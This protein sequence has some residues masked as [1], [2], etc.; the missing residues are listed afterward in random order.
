MEDRLFDGPKPQT[1]WG[2]GWARGKHV[3]VLDF[4]FLKLEGF[5]SETLLD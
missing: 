4:H 5:K 3:L 1:P 2:G